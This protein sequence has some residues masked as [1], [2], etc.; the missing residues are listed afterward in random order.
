MINF[1]IL[2][3][4][5]YINTSSTTLKLT[6]EMDFSKL[7]QTLIL[8]IE[9]DQKLHSMSQLHKQHLLDPVCPTLLDINPLKFKC[10]VN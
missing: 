10:R 5:D 8:F 7:C 3:L 9:F 2:I 4:N 6:Q 1:T